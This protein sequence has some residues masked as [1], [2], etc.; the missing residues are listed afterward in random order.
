MW[1]CLVVDVID[2]TNCSNSSKSCI[3]NSQMQLKPLHTLLCDMITMPGSNSHRSIN[4]SINQSINNNTYYVAI[5]RV[6][7]SS[8]ICM[9]SLLIS[10]LH[11]VV[12]LC[13]YSFLS[14]LY[15]TCWFKFIINVQLNTAD[16]VQAH[17][18]G[19]YAESDHVHCRQCYTVQ[20]LNQADS[21]AVFKWFHC[22]M[23]ESCRLKQH[24]RVW[25]RVSIAWHIITDMV[26]EITRCR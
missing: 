18:A 12:L 11:T 19:D 2:R 13:F 20:L 9:P 10:A 6:L 8:D 24:T 21:A 16:K 1:L 14:S 4:Q 25:Y 7:A 15:S 5:V 22:N 3:S 17:T 23:R 26:S